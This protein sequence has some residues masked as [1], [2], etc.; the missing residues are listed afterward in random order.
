VFSSQIAYPI[1]L[2]ENFASFFYNGSLLNGDGSSITTP[3][4][5]EDLSTIH[6]KQLS[7]TMWL[8]NTKYPQQKLTR[9]TPYYFA[10]NPISFDRGPFLT[11]NDIANDDGITMTCSATNGSGTLTASSPIFQ[12]GH[13]GALFQLTHPLPAASAV[14]STTGATPSSLI[15]IKGNFSFNTHGTWSGTVQLLRTQGSNTSEVYRTFIGLGDRNIQL[16]ATENDYDVTYQ[17]NPLA[18]MS[19][20]FSADI[21]NNTS[22]ASG[23]V[24]ITS[25]TNSVTAN[26]TILHN[27]VSTSATLRWAEGAWSAVQGYPTSVCFFGDRCIYAGSNKVWLSKVGDYENFD[28]DVKDADS[29]WV[30]LTT[31]ESITWVDTVDDMIV[32]GTTGI[33][34]TLGSNKVGTPITPTNFT[35]REQSG[36]GSTFIQGV[37]INNAILFSDFVGKKILELAYNPSE[38]KY[39][40]PDLTV[41]SENIT[42]SSTIAGFC[43][44]KNP[45]SMLWVWMNDGT[46]LSMTYQRD[47]QVIAWAK[48]PIDGVVTSVAVIPAAEEDEVWLSIDRTINNSTVTC[49]ERFAQ[50]TLPSDIEDMF[51]VDCG[52]TYDGVAATTIP[53]AHLIGKTVSILADGIVLPNQV[54][55]GSGNITL[56]TPA[57]KVQVGLPYIPKLSP[58]RIDVNSA[59]G[60]IHGSTRKTAELVVSLV[61]T[62][63]SAIKY[64]SDDND[65]K[66]VDLTTVDLINLSDSND[67]F[68]GDVK[69]VQDGGFSI[70]DPIL[71]TSDVPLPLTVRGII[72][73]LDITSR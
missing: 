34:W 68:T 62:G 17:I 69:V 70:D 52:I 41:L 27:L 66:S 21:T 2:G 6:Y 49:V 15:S 33:P 55:D 46:L 12:S 16:S 71:I 24:Q 53:V 10:I 60:S 3:Y 19:S 39:L 47:Q 13:V 7:D 50:R 38:S 18:G 61:N 57:S 26:V 45:E 30:T 67:L 44:Q 11:R 42:N 56:T 22:I 43:H 5:G 32:I 31:G 9:L 36:F 4:L 72:S 73:R 35:A 48:H 29:F 54:V 58:M 63:F 51:F 40:T 59:S 8:V 14:V 28:S 20:G 37:K 25:V 1:E 23:I 64:G 65:Q